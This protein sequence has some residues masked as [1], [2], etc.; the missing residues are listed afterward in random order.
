MGPADGRGRG[1]QPA[2]YEGV[3]VE[4]G[5][6]RL[7]AQADAAGARAWVRVAGGVSAARPSGLG[8]YAALDGRQRLDFGSVVARAGDEGGSARGG[9]R[10]TP[11][12][13]WACVVV[14]R[15]VAPGPSD[16]VG[17]HA[18]RRP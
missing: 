5:W 1:G 14:R 2:E 13:V 11:A 15:R 18:R 8:E 16:R 9:G 17:R 7:E 12:S 3:L 10:T 4:N 6:F